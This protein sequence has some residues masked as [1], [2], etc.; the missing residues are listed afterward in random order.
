MR[1]LILVALCAGTAAADSSEPGF[2]HKG[3]LELS[4]RGALGMRAIATYETTDYCGET[5]TTTASGN[6]AVC[7]GR[8]PFTLDFEPAYGIARAIDLFVELRIGLEAEFGTTSA[9]ND[10][11]HAFHLSPGARFYFADARRL[12]LF[13]TAQVVFDFTGYKKLD[14]SARGSDFGLRNMSGLW[15]DLTRDYGVYG[16]VGETATVVRWLGFHMEAGVGVQ[17]RYR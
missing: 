1:A 13:T 11:P 7:V 14:G 4:V 15:L 2:T 9:T 17:G 16:F 12:K 8:S 5:D 10:G 3:Q 6:A